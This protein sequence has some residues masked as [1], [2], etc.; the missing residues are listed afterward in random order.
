MQTAENRKIIKN[1]FYAKRDLLREY[2]ADSRKK[3]KN[4]TYALLKYFPKYIYKIKIEGYNG[5]T[6]TRLKRTKVIHD[7]CSFDARS[8]RKN[9]WRLL[10][11]NKTRSVKNIY[12]ES[13]TSKQMF[14]EIGLFYFNERI[15]I[16][17]LRLR[18]VF[19]TQEEIIEEMLSRSQETE[20]DYVEEMID[21]FRIASYLQRMSK[22]EF[23]EIG[24]DKPGLV[25]I[26]WLLN[27]QPRLRNLKDFHVSFALSGSGYPK[28]L[29]DIVEGTEIFNYVSRLSL[30]YIDEGGF[31]TFK[32][33]PGQCGNVR[34]LSL[35][36]GDYR[37]SSFEPDSDDED[38][39][40]RRMN[41]E[42]YTRASDFL[43]SLGAFQNLIT[44]DIQVGS[45]F[46]FVRDF[47]LPAC[48]RNVWIEFLDLNWYYLGARL[49]KIES[50]LATPAP[51]ET[52]MFVDFFNRWE[53]L[54]FV[55]S[56]KITM[57]NNG[58][59]SIGES[60]AVNEEFYCRILE[61]VKNIKELVLLPGI[62]YNEAFKLKT[63]MEKLKKGLEVLNI[64]IIGSFA[65]AEE[66][67]EKIRLQD[68]VSVKLEGRMLEDFDLKGFLRVIDR[69]FEKK[70]CE[71]ELNRFEGL[72]RQDFVKL[73]EQINEVGRLKNI[74]LS[75]KA[76]VYYHEPHLFYNELK[77]FFEKSKEMKNVTLALGVNGH[78]KTVD[79]MLVSIGKLFKKFDFKEL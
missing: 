13:M 48:I 72:R 55:D 56:L 46:Y 4:S 21:L 9:L 42:A 15:K 64:S 10:L 8:S 25:V 50:G 39:E 2:D 37:P 40:E 30:D 44:I 26:L 53:Q 27:S 74:D 18:R 24:I 1:I 16:A 5:R 76:R 38:A 29:R 34:Y 65:I 19:K 67:L 70:A 52:Q 79:D 6:I 12:S 45:L 73:L 77:E 20:E 78:D 66:D 63:L 75:L 60:S 49:D 11:A 69:C 71:I 33:L 58:P 68:L 51:F 59:G 17:R 7:L 61:R 62:Q 57:K 23:L 32:M 22:L 35:R 47:T 36:N 54:S 41:V 14:K 31:E 3:R 28:E 43:Q